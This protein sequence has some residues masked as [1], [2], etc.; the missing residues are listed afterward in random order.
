M[1]HKN[2][3]PIGSAVL[4]TNK[5]T[6]KP[7][8]YI[9]IIVTLYQRIIVVTLYQ[10]ISVLT[11]YC[12]NLLTN[13]HINVSMFQCFNVST[14]QYQRISVLTSYCINLLTNKHINVSMFQCINVLTYQ[15]INIS[16]CKQ[17]N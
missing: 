4:Q 13:K 11:S 6:D 8:L 3:G 10:R 14:Y 12:I 2:L 5:Q 15:Y 16:T 1:S 7:N 17:I 9:D